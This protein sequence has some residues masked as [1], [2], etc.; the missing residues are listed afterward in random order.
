MLAVNETAAPA[1]S[2]G[3]TMV[4]SGRVESPAGPLAGAV[5]SVDGKTYQKAVTNID[6]EFHLTV[7]TTTEALAITASYAGFRDVS[8]AVQP[9][10]AL[11]LLR[12]TEQQDI[13]LKRHLQLKAY[14]KGAHKEARRESRKLRRA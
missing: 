1:R 10:T 12:L 5:V 4:I 7:P 2:T 9:G 8:A 6:G 13:K 14:L 11:A 3:A